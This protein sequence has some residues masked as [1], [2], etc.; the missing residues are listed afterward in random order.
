[1][2]FKINYKLLQHFDVCSNDLQLYTFF[3]LLKKY[4]FYVILNA[5]VFFEN[6]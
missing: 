3:K 1:M 2:V 5:V 6:P 4:K